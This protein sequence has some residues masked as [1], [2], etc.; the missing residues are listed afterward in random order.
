LFDLLTGLAS[1][2]PP[3]TPPASAGGIAVRTLSRIVD[4]PQASAFDAAA[5][6]A[7]PAP[8]ENANFSGGLLGRLTALAGLDPQ[9]P[10]QPAS[11]PLDDQLFYRDDPAQP[12]FAQLRR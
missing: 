12:W 3:P 1:R 8:A 6:F 10:T 5:P 2:N 9:N 7:P 4:P 11:P